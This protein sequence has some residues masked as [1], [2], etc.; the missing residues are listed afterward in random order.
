MVHQYKL[1]G[2]N[3][4]LDSCSGAIHVV[5]EVAY[6]IIAM[7]KEKDTQTIVDEIMAVYGIW[8]H[9]RTQDGHAGYML[10]K[11]LGGDQ[12][13]AVANAAPLDGTTV[14]LLGSRPVSA[15][16]HT[17]DGYVFAFPESCIVADLTT[18][19]VTTVPAESLPF[20]HAAL[21]GTAT[22]P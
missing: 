4:V 8:A 10:L 14:R 13:A 15:W 21:P 3:I 2:F 22:T 12:P 17:A 20:W 9:V 18:G 1:N 5:D 7:I 6:D 11:H 19:A 16:Q